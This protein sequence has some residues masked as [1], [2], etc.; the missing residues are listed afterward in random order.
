MVKKQQYLDYIQSAGEDMPGYLERSITY[1]RD[2]FDPNNALFG[3]SATG[4]PAAAAAI[5]AFQYE[6][7]GEIRYAEQAKAALLIPRELSEIFPAETAACHPEYHQAVPPMDGLFVPPNYIPAYERVRNSG[8]LSKEDQRAVESIVADSLHTLFHFPEWGAHNRTMLRALSM[9]LA[10]RAFPDNHQA[11]E[12][13]A[14]SRQMAEDSWGRWSIEDAM[15]Y[16]AVWM[17]ALFTYA[18]V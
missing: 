10:Y 6:I 16:H 7:T 13:Q 1:W 14:L 8:V 9:A 2:N 11:N 18:E 12:W 3:Y 15:G 4:A 17:L 5:D